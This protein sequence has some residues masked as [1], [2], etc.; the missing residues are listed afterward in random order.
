MKGKQPKHVVLNLG[1]AESPAVQEAM[2]TL[3]NVQKELQKKKSKVELIFLRQR[4]QLNNLV[5]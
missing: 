1:R 5:I 2:T 3:D 4:K